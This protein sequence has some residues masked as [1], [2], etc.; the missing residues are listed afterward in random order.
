M[1]WG[2]K[3]KSYTFRDSKNEQSVQGL[4]Y[5]KKVETNCKNCPHR[6]KQANGTD[7]PKAGKLSR[8]F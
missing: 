3:S 2:D 5:T 6:P 8:I 4:S 7:H 1:P